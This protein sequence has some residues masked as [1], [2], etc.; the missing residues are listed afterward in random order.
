MGRVLGRRAAA[1]LIMAMVTVHIGLSQIPAAA[2][3]DDSDHSGNVALVGSLELPGATDVVLTDDGY[4][5][6]VVNGSNL[7]YAGLWVVDISDPAVPTPVGHLPCVG[8]GYD[9]GLWNDIAV[10]SID[11]PGDNA[12]PPD[13]GCNLDGTVGQEGIRLVDISD[14]ANPREV[15]FVETDCGSHTNITFD[16]DGRGLVYVQSYP[17]S[18]S[19]ACPSLHGVISVVDITDPANPEIVSQPSVLPA[20]GCHDGSIHGEHAYMAC[21]TEGQ[22]WDV[23]DPVNPSIVAHLNDVPDA[24]WHSSDV[25]NDG[26][27][28]AFGWESFGGGNASCTGAAQG[29]IGAIH[30]YDVSDPANPVRLGFFSP[31]RQVNGLCTAHNFTV[32]PDTDRDVLVTAWYGAGFMVVDFTDP[33]APEELGHYV[34]GSTSTWDANFRDGLAY[35][36]DGNRG[37][38]IYRIDEL[39]T[40]TPTAAPENSPD[41]DTAAAPTPAPTL[42]VTGGGMA[43][44]APLAAFLLGR[45]RRRGKRRCA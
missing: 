17:A 32:V 28:A 37:L 8:S 39:A 18:T 2:D 35:V 14:R 29:P 42:P 25:S 3:H 40:A 34:P 30:F 22:I 9:V 11:S 26:T 12:S 38:D 44:L 5:V 16:H 21:L 43:A 15:A 24:I 27:V 41:T 23:S 10:M 19:G 1:T 36:G 31:P 6:Q 33:S 45:S 4:A 20:V 13:R 7:D